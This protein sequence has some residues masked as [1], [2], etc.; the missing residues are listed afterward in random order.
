MNFNDSIIQ[1]LKEGLSDSEII[2]N[3]YSKYAI[4]LNKKTLLNKRLMEYFLCDDV[5]GS[6]KC[7]EWKN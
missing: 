7:V 3:I 1:Y 4:V 6:I 5:G 2:S